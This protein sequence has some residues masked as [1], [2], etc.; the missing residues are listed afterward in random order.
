MLLFHV[1]QSDDYH[2]KTIFDLD[3]MY[4]NEYEENIPKNQDR[5]SFFLLKDKTQTLTS[6]KLAKENT[7]L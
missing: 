7:K 1:K 3:Y 4:A 6:Q 5:S 2:L